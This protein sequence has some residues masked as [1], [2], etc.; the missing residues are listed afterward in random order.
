MELLIILILEKCANFLNCNN[1]KTNRLDNVLFLLIDS[2]KNQSV[3]S[4]ASTTVF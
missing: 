4:Y 1:K 2:S 3:G